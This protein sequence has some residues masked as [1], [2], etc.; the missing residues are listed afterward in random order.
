MKNYPLSII[1]SAFMVIFLSTNCEVE[2][3]CPQ[4][5]T[6]LGKE[7]VCNQG[8]VV[9][10]DGGCDPLPCPENSTPDSNG[11]C[12]CNEGYIKTSD[13]NCIPDN[14]VACPENSS[15]SEDLLACKCNEGFVENEDGECVELM[16]CQ[17]NATFNPDTGECECDEGYEEDY[18]GDCVM[19]DGDGCPDNATYD[20]TFEE[21]KCDEG[22]FPSE[23]GESCN[24]F[25]PESL[26]GTHRASQSCSGTGDSDYFI[27][28]GEIFNFPEVISVIGLFGYV[29]T[30][31]MD[32]NDSRTRATIREGEVI[33]GQSVSGWL[34]LG[35]DA[36]G[37]VTSLEL[38]AEF[39]G[40]SCTG[41]FDKLEDNENPCAENASLVNLQCR[42]DQGYQELP[43]TGDCVAFDFFGVYDCNQ[44]CSGLGDSDYDVRIEGDNYQGDPNYILIINLFETNQPLRCELNDD[45]SGA[46]VEPGQILWGGQVGNDVILSGELDFDRQSDG[47]IENVV[48]TYSTDTG[49]SCTAN[50][51]AQ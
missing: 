25:N 22:F 15:Y 45:Y 35:T 40:E 41:T 33:G 24:A 44:S 39:G 1:I 14:G 34:N 38:E 26:Y 21:C 36:D 50:L 19:V 42:C 27:D 12:K 11:E 6:R 2:T 30:A 28:I 32:L 31:I 16:A 48:F 51:T 49:E 23:D 13:G 20:E 7:C 17:E 5:S 9:N 43:A 18:Y 3:P 10:S 29:E 47:S 46:T 4:N 37:N 8:Y